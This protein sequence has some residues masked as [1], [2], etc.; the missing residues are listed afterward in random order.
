MNKIQV[1]YT[2]WFGW[3]AVYCQIKEIKDGLLVVELE[4]DESVGEIRA[5]DFT[6]Q[7]RYG[8]GQDKGEQQ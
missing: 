2:G 5:S 3:P 6:P 8:A 1:G 4:A 7:Y